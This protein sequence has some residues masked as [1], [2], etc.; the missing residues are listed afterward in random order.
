MALPVITPEARAEALEKAHAARTQRAELRLSLK[1]GTI[2]L[3][4]VLK[5]AAPGSVI[6]KTKVSYLLESMPG[7]GNVRAAEIMERLG[8][9]EM[10]RVQGLGDNQRAALRDE[11]APV[12]A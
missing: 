3:P 11:F 2:T 6:G 8:I 10:R 5:Q 1:H 12:P 9:P 7:V 4:D